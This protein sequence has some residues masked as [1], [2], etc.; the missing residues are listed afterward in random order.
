[1]S[2]A[3]KECLETKFWLNLLKDTDYISLKEFNSIYPD[4]DEISKMLFSILKLSRLTK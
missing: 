2:I 4:V 3:Y 1:M